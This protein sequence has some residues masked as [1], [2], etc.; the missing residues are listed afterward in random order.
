MRVIGRTF[1]G[2]PISFDIDVQPCESD[3]VALAEAAIGG[4]TGST[5]TASS[6]AA[7]L[8]NASAGTITT[9]SLSTAAGATYTLT[10]T[11]NL[12][13]ASSL[14]FPVVTLG[15]A[16]TGTACVTH[17]TPAAGSVT[18]KVQ[19]IHASAPFNGTLKIGFLIC[20]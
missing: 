2:Q 12:I 5:A 7:T 9:E 1:S 13:K 6:G 4:A 16:T 14:V 17:V 8:N 19:N 11:N 10:L 3:V 20:Q 18:I 15:S